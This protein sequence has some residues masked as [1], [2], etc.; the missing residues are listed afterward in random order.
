MIVVKYISCPI[1]EQK[2]KLCY[3]SENI[4]TK[5]LILDSIIDGYTLCPIHFINKIIKIIG[6][7]SNKNRRFEQLI[8][9]NIINDLFLNQSFLC[10][11]NCESE[12]IGDIV[13][14]DNGLLYRRNYNTSKVEITALFGFVFITNELYCELDSFNVSD[15]IYD[16][17]LITQLL[18]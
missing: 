12:P 6:D 14:L 18:Y 10:T 4:E 1:N 2:F 7:N 16:Y 3:L 17:P 8:T 13:L 9:Y 15:N 11:V 5:K